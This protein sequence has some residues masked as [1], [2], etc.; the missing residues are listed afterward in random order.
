MFAI[1]PDSEVGTGSAGRQP[2]NIISPDIL[3]GFYCGAAVETL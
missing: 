1:N 2:G 3:E